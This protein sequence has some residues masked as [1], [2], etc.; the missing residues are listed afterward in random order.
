MAVTY[1]GV[2]KGGQDVS[3]VTVDTST[4]SSDIEL[5]VDD[6]NIPA[7]DVKAKL[8]ILQGMIAIQAKLEEYDY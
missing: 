3:A 8:Q 7:A 5:A 4:T 6:T 1:F 2:D